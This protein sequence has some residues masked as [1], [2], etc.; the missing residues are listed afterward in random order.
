MANERD[1]GTGLDP[2]APARW[3]VA[4]ARELAQAPRTLRRGREL[5]EALAL[6]PVQLERVLASLERTTGFLENSVG[7][8]TAAVGSGLENRIEH[9]DDTVSE[10]RDTIAALIGAIPGARRVLQTVTRQP[11][12]G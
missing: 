9:L 6:L 4:L 11:R 7:Q 3:G 10:L 12:P 1:G 8:L 2:L 5:V